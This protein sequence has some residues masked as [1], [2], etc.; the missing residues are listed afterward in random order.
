MTKEVRFKDTRQEK[1]KQH[2]RNELLFFRISG[3]IRRQTF[4]NGSGKGALGS[5]EKGEFGRLTNRQEN[6]FGKQKPPSPTK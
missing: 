5:L 2:V 4:E 1:K 6:P 3:W